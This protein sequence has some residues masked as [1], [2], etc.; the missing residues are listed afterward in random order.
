MQ[1]RKLLF[2]LAIIVIFAG[3]PKEDESNNN[4]NNFRFTNDYWGEWIRLDT[5]ETWYLND[6]E[7]QVHNV[8]YPNQ[9]SLRKENKNAIEVTEGSRKYYIYASRIKGSSFKG[10]VVDGSGSVIGGSEQ[11]VGSIAVVISNL[12]NASDQTTVTT[13][14]D[15]N[16]IVEDI[17]PWDTYTVT[18]DGKTWTVTPGDGDDVGIMAL[19]DGVNLKAYLSADDAD[20]FFYANAIEGYEYDIRIDLYLNIANVGSRTVSTGTYAYYTIESPGID[21]PGDTSFV[22]PGQPIF[23][24]GLEPGYRRRTF[25][26][27][28]S[29]PITGEFETKKIAITIVDPLANV[30]WKDY[31]SIKIRSPVPLYIKSQTNVRGIVIAPYKKAYFVGGGYWDDN[32]CILLPWNTDDYLLILASAGQNTAYSLG[33]GIEPGTQWALLE[34]RNMYKPQDTESTAAPIGMYEEKMAFLFASGIDYWRINMG[35]AKP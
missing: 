15:G 1:E 16:Y 8:P 32:P 13:D 29:E 22:K 18:V 25:L 6:K 33:V 4:V 5:G 12:A 35:N 27:F 10:R 3:C 7:I 2:M 20:R 28:Y 30:T 14:K 24:D 11:G 26:A 34:D 31:A 9:L 17:I 23:L 19:R 21:P